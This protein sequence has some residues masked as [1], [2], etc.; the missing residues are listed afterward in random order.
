MHDGPAPDDEDD[1]EED[2]DDGQE[3]E[4]DEDDDDCVKE[5]AVALFLAC[6]PSI[7]SVSDDSAPDLLVLL[8][9]LLHE[10]ANSFIRLFLAWISVIIFARRQ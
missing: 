5:A 1:D 8:L 7:E 4:E 9:L 6:G 10:L 2:E 3:D